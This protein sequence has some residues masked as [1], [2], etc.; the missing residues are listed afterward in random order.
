M[1]E[2]HLNVLILSMPQS[3]F[4]LIHQLFQ[5]RNSSID[6]TLNKATQILSTQGLFFKSRIQDYR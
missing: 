3:I 1:W 2:N 6:Q 5:Q 4:Y